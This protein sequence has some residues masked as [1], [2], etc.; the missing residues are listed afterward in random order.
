MLAVPYTAAKKAAVAVKRCCRN[1]AVCR[2]PCAAIPPASPYTCHTP[3]AYCWPYRSTARVMPLATPY[4]RT[5]A[6][7]KIAETS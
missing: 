7:A 1:A 6:A 4:R 5:I 3:F 2:L